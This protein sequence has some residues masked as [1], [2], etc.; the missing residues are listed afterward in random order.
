MEQHRWQRI[1][2]VFNEVVDLPSETEQAARLDALTAGDDDMRRQVQALLAEEATLRRGDA[3]PSS[4]DPHVGL[5]LG[6]FA[7]G[8]LVGRG[9]MAAVYEGQRVDGAF[10]QRVAVKIMDLRLSDPA[11]VARFKAERQILAGLEHPSV[12]RLLD[13][14]V[15]ALGEPYLVMEF[16]EGQPI[17]RYCDERR[18]GLDARVALFGQVCEAVTYAHR[19]LVLHRDLKPSNILVTGEGRVKVVDFGTATLLQPDRL[20]TTTVAPLTPAYASP[21]QLTGA[22]VGTASD[23]YS[24]GIVLF[25]LLTGGMP[26]GER[27]SLLAAMERALAGSTTTAPHAA[28]TAE[29]AATRQTSLARLRRTLS[30]DLGTIV[31]KAL[32]PDQIA[33]YASVQ[34]FADDL[35]R[36][37]RGEPILGR[38]ASRAYLTARFL[39]RHWVAASLAAVLALALAAATGVSVQQA[40]LARAEAERARV[41]SQRAQVESQRA[42]AFNGFLTRMLSAANPLWTNADA[43]RAGTMS[44]RDVLDGAGQLIA[45]DAALAPEVEA[46]IRL[47]LGAT[48]A[49][50][51]VPAAARE[52][53]ERA[54]ALATRLG[55]AKEAATAQRHLTTTYLASGNPQEAER[56]ARPSLDYAR[57]HSDADPESHFILANDL[58][59]ALSYQGRRDEARRFLRE[60]ADVIERHG[61]R[62]AGAAAVVHNLGADLSQQGDYALA[63][64]YMRRSLAMLESLPT[65]PAEHAMALRT[66]ADL[67]LGQQRHPEALELATR[68]A[69]E[70][71]R[72]WPD[73]YPH[74]HS[75]RATLGNALTA[76]GRPAEGRDALQS[77]I[78]SWGR[79]RPPGHIDTLLPLIGLAAAERA[80]GHRAEALEIARRAERGLDRYPKFTSRGAAAREVG[81]TL[82]AMGRETEARVALQRSY[83]VY[84]TIAGEA[85]PNTTAA[86]ARL[87]PRGVAPPSGR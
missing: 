4:A 46:D 74:R 77:A 49:G 25:E 17:D 68:A 33:R 51:N 29:A 53:L 21:E 45:A 6:P 9:G 41:E 36:W 57:A 8:R 23:Q 26:F 39:Q 54:L 2:S 5:R 19:A 55:L 61:I 84:R 66:L 63:E 62:S 3:A 60:A 78:A 28:V 15:T 34:H 75:V 58:S 37:S 24:L 83:E 48:Y 27:P 85:H 1:E 16:V 18:L 11:L 22:P 73:T 82:R 35:T 59:L 14:G 69:A 52:H 40:R 71:D 65:L 44:V 12:T 87:D 43:A 38:P 42:T 64:Q 47:S 13:G 50:L 32:A 67:L 31:T 81:L 70:A 72:V 79:V 76:V 10:T 86:L 20:A 56:Q 7:V 80:L 30:S